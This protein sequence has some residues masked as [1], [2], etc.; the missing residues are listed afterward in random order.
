MSYS[1]LI[2]IDFKLLWID[3]ME[4]AWVAYLSATVN[5]GTPGAGTGDAISFS[6]PWGEGRL[7]ERSSSSEAPALVLDQPG[8]SDLLYVGP[9]A[10]VGSLAALL[11]LSWPSLIVQ[12]ITA[13]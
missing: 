11:A 13:R 3:T 8:D 9:L 5:G 1:P 12:V 7:L 2:P 6:I 10:L 4:I